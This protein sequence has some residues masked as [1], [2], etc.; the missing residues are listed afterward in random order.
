MADPAMQA[1]LV[2]LVRRNRRPLTIG[3]IAMQ[4]GV[5]RPTAAKY[6]DIC[7]AAGLLRST[8]FATARQVTAKGGRIR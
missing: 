6:V 2:A 7:E 8:W 3:E 1:E 4:W 5:S